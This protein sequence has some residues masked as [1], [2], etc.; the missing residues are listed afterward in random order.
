[1]ISSVPM[2]AYRIG[3]TAIGLQRVFQP[4]AFHHRASAIVQMIVSAA[5][6]TAS[7]SQLR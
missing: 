1:V 6:V 7:A 2:S 3:V 4:L 5:T